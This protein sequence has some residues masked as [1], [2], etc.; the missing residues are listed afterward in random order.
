MVGSLLIIWPWKT[1]HYIKMET[2]EKVVGYDWYF[3]SF[4]FDMII[5]VGLMVLGFILVSGIERLLEK[6][7]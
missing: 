6:D 7:E 4:D 2:R 5:G 1:P 3:P